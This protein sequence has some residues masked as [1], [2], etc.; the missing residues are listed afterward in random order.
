MDVVAKGSEMLT[1]Y[2][3]RNNLQADGPIRVYPYL[4]IDEGPPTAEDL[5]RVIVRLEL[6]IR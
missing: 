1:T 5:A 3:Q 2:G 6:P 4:F